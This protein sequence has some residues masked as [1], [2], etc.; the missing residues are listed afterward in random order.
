MVKEVREENCSEE[1][2]DA[3]QYQRNGILRYEKVFGHTFIST[4]GKQTTE[5]CTF[6][7]FDD[8]LC[9]QLW[10]AIPT[11]YILWLP[12]KLYLLS[13]FNFLNIH[14][15]QIRETSSHILCMSDFK[16]GGNNND[17]ATNTIEPQL[18]TLILI[19]VIARANSNCGNDWKVHMHLRAINYCSS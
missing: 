13:S 10:S 6:Y 7:S 16:K 8:I 4:G 1:F 14:F 12:E 5:V 3:G 17:S 19:Y 9:H 15:S 2:M 11:M 18:E